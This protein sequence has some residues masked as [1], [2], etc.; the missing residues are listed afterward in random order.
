MQDI[1]VTNARIVTAD[2]VIDGTLAVRGGRIAA[3]S[4]GPSAAAGE[5]WD[6]DYLLPGLVELHTDNVERHLLPRPGVQWPRT[7]AI[8]AHDA[9]VASAG[10]TTVF[11]ALRV[12]EW[13]NEGSIAGYLDDMVEA[14]DAADRA[15]LF[16]ADHLIHLRCEVCCRDTAERFADFAD[17]PRLRL[18]S[19]M[20]HTPGQRQFARLDKF[21]QYYSGKYHL[22]GPA[23]DA[24]I[25]ER[26]RA[27]EK[28][29]D[30]HRKAI[31]AQSRER[32]L[33]LAS[34]DDATPEH[35]TE[36]VDDGM[37]IAE[38]PT[39][40]DAAEKSRAHGLAVLMGAPNVVRG[41]SHSGNV[42]ALDLAGR[43]LLDILSSDYVPSSLLHAAFL[44][45]ERIPEITLPAAVQS[46]TRTP[47]RA[48]GLDDRGEIAPGKRADMI[49]VRILGGSPVVLSVWREGRRVA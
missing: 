22:K 7:Q 49:R 21:V 13:D 23:L 34:H 45:T 6:G 37:H 35:V 32:G 43:G 38:F 20:D 18:V 33:A 12:G 42:S 39:S 40:V 41:G 47:A 10:I 29:S 5:N 2:A 48:V 27:R 8:M 36:A 28:Y 4:K 1:T 26:M 30:R 9:E 11:D 16:R 19:L 17:H 15:G 44:L 46:V 24:F 14:I 3:L 25:A 31:V